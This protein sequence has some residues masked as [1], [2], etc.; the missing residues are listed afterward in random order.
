MMSLAAA[1]RESVDTSAPE[2]GLFCVRQ[3]LSLADLRFMALVNLCLKG[4]LQ[5]GRRLEWVC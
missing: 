3:S 4:R 2:A 1:R 5:E